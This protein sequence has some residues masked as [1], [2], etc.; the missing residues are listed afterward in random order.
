M[1]LTIGG[2]IRRKVQMRDD[3]I[4]L[5]C[6]TILVN[7]VQSFTLSAVIIPQLCINTYFNKNGNSKTHLNS[8]FTMFTVH[9]SKSCHKLKTMLYKN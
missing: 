1:H 4:I 6:I 9:K 3:R 2:V 5:F 7:T 8:M